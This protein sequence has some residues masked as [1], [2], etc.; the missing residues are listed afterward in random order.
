MTVVRFMGTTG[1]VTRRDVTRAGVHRPGA[2]RIGGAPGPGD[3]H[4][5]AER[6]EGPDVWER[7]YLGSSGGAGWRR[8]RRRPRA[9]AASPRTIRRGPPPTHGATGNRGRAGAGGGGPP[10]LF[11]TV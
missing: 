5:G 2:P 7:P 6:P 9:N 8:A 11:G 3:Q 1:H 10:P 4:A